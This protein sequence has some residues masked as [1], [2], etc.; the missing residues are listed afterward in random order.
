LRYLS[1]NAQEYV[2]RMEE[3]LNG[4]VFIQCYFDFI[5]IFV[6]VFNNTIIGLSVVHD[7]LRSKQRVKKRP[8]AKSIVTDSNE[9]NEHQV[10]K[11]KYC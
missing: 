1:I 11:L 8:R 3:A 6:V 4:L 7:E 5:S 2:R 9:I 10:I